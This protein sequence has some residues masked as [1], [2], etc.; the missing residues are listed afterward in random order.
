MSEGAVQ[1][2]TRRAQDWTAK[3]EPLVD[4]FRRLKGKSAY[5]D[6]E[7]VV[8]GEDGLSD[9][10]GLQSWFKTGKGRLVF[11]AF[12][13]LFLDGDDLRGLPLI[14]RKARLREL[15]AA[16]A[17]TRLLF[18]DHQRGDGPAFFKAATHMSVEGIISKQADAPYVSGR[19]RDWLKIK[20][21]ERQEFV[22][23]GFARSTVSKTSIG[24]LLMGEYVGGKLVYVGKVGTG[25]TNA[26]AKELFAKLSKDTRDDPPFESVPSDVRRSPIWV[27]PKHV[28][29]V[30]FGAWTS[31]HIL[32][33]A[34]FQGLREDKTPKDVHTEK[35]EPV[36]KS[37]VESAKKAAKKAVVVPKDERPEVLG[38]GISHPE[39]LIFP[40]KNITKRDV[41]DYYAAVAKVMLPYVADRPLALVRCPDGVGPACFFQKHAGVGLPEVIREERIGRGKDDT[42]LLVD[43]AEGLV[44]LVQRGVLEIH[45]WGSHIGKIE[46]ADIAVFDFDPDPAVKWPK[47][48][49]A[50][51]DMRAFLKKL[52]LASF[53]KTT[54][55]KG[56][57]VVVPFK[58]LLEWDAIKE[59]TRTVADKFAAMD[60]DMYLINMSKKKREG[61]IF[62]DYLRNGRGSTAIAPYS[63][64]A[65]PGALIATPLSW[66]ELESGAK[67]QHFGMDAV[68]ARV[69]K[70]FK[71]PWKEML[72]TKQS[73]TEKTITTLMAL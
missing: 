20:R 33:H 51:L 42:V 8:I 30:E 13:L 61:K 19:G 27:E 21:I 52:G 45:C 6:G 22:I 58:P 62:I 65:R 14:A 63:T 34:S 72:G 57:H 43:S 36:K 55:G 41:A 35:V 50:A 44:S 29:E 4:D 73:I 66:A 16:S 23:G 11:Y 17:G 15:L 49:D 47:V 18:S 3:F 5:L 53:V 37:L 48:V 26:M 25:Y 56:L 60:P 70:S 31:D 54:G 39:R 7:A 46:Q 24:A 10:S 2:L 68:I 67:P 12:D 28:A 1:L 71:D 59:F 64:R 9:F 38:I 69:S 40:D 32:R